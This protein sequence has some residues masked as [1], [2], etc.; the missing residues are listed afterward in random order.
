MIYL[1]S[2]IYRHHSRNVLIAKVPWRSLPVEDGIFERFHID[3]LSLPKVDEYKH[4]L[5]AVD[6]FSLYTVLL[7]AKSTTAEEA[8]RLIYTNIYI[9]I[10]IS[11]EVHV[12]AL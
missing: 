4:V 11:L 7:P 10:Y 2:M 6:L 9:Y 8:A 5:V 12:L 1:H 3:F